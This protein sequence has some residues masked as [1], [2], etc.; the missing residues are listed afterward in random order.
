MGAESKWKSWWKKKPAE[1]KMTVSNDEHDEIGQES[2]DGAEIAETGDHW[3]GL[4]SELGAE[5]PPAE[6]QQSEVSSAEDLPAAFDAVA[7]SAKMPDPVTSDWGGLATSLGIDVS[8][9]NAA[10]D[11]SSVG[12]EAVEEKRAS[13]GRSRRGRRSRREQQAEAAKNSDEA[14]IT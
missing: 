6:S 9:A 5:S 14:E 1:E 4:A 2:A 11:D 8:D 12:G 10:N 7:S 3:G 13:R